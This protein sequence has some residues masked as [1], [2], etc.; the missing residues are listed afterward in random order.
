MSSACG[1]DPP[2]PAC[3]P[4]FSAPRCSAPAPATSFFDRVYNDGQIHLVV[5][6][7]R[8]GRVVTQFTF[9]NADNSRHM[10]D[11]VSGKRDTWEKTR[12]ATNKGPTTPSPARSQRLDATGS[13]ETHTTEVRP[14]QPGDL[15][16]S[17]PG[18]AAE[19]PTQRARESF[20][21]HCNPGR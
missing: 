12:V 4:Q 19:P 13:T 2:V 6:T 17:I 1:A 5:T 9:N 18:A 14:Q 10:D 8:E 16:S 7:P 21:A 15:S 20:V 3:P 11:V